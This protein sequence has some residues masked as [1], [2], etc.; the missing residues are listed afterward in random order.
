MKKELTMENALMEA[1]ASPTRET[2]NSEQ[3]PN[4]T[5]MKMRIMARKMLW[6]TLGTL[7]MRA[8]TS[9]VICKLIKTPKLR[10]QLLELQQT[11]SIE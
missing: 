9:T 4:R 3:Q 8:D 2:M 1:K 5:T 11:P 6:R 10:H 7:S